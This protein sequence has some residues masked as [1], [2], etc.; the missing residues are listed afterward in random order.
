MRF[1]RIVAALD[2]ARPAALGTAVG[3][4]CSLEAELVGVF[5]EDAELLELAALPFDEVGF[6]SPVRRELDVGRM[7]R[8]LRAKARR[9]EQQLGSRLAGLPV[10]WSF[11]VVRG[12]FA[13]AV[14]TIATA[15]DIVVVASTQGAAVPPRRGADIA[16][17]FRA[18]RSPVLVVR[19]PLPAGDRLAIITTHGPLDDVARA[20][21]ALAP[22]YGNAA[23]IVLGASES[24]EPAPTPGDLERLLAGHGVRIDVRMLARRSRV[25]L[26]RLLA[27]APRGIVVVPTH[28]RAAYKEL[29]DLL[30]CPVLF[31]PEGDPGLGRVQR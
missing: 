5:V 22:R 26:E 3:L 27:E 11:E 8:G 9:I 24:E 12:R 17:A 1:R 29:L 21:A 18:L 20:I 4:A 25:T 30:P 28:S 15:D 23:L 2:T 13:A 10:K 7:E 16:D 6:P 19:D 31:L 14:T